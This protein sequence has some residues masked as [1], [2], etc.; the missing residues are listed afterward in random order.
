MSLSEFLNFDISKYTVDTVDTVD[1]VV[2]DK[3]DL[4]NEITYIE[5]CIANL[6]DEIRQ[7]CVATPLSPLT[8]AC[9]NSSQCGD[10]DNC[11]FVHCVPG[12]PVM[13]CSLDKMCLRVGCENAH[14]F[15][16]TLEIT[17]MMCPMEDDCD[18]EQCLHSHAMCFLDGDC[19]DEEC[20]D[21]HTM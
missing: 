9:P 2:V 7:L 11:P 12:V 20:E 3:F 4:M 13:L 17:N 19:T 16:D 21:A 10:I 5:F 1:M 15:P 8:S 18:D 6:N 14:T